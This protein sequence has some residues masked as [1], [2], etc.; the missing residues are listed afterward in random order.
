MYS[1]ALGEP[2][3]SFGL[4]NTLMMLLCRYLKQY[5]DS[6]SIVMETVWGIF[7]YMMASDNQEVRRYTLYEQGVVPFLCTLVDHSNVQILKPVLGSLNVYLKGASTGMT[8]M[9]IDIALI[10]SLYRLASNK[11][12]RLIRASAF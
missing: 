12:Y 6:E 3:P 7:W 4:A 5:K 8:D 9:V 2:Y 1:N 11:E 10:E